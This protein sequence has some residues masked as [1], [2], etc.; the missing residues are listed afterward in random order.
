MMNNKSNYIQDNSID[1]Q[2]SPAEVE[3]WMLI[4][5]VASWL[6]PRG[7]RPGLRLFWSIPRSIYYS[8]NHNK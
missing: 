8:N 3:E 5:R 7:S 2:A 4:L 6:A 1:V